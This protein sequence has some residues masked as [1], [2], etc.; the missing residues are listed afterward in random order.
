M[1]ALAAAAIFVAATVLALR[2]A[3]PWATWYYP[4]AW[5]PVLVC[6]DV[7]VARL[8]GR[9]L[10]L[11]RPRRALSLLLWSVPVWLLFEAVNF[12]VENWY[13]VFVPDRRPAAWAGIT[14]SFATILPAIFL[15]TT[16]VGEVAGRGSGPRW[17]R[18]G[19]TPVRLRGIRL[20][21]V[22]MA[23]L[24]L[25]WPR[26]FFPLVWG[27]VT[28]LVEPSNYRRHRGTSLLA[29]LEGGRP[30]RILRLVAAGAA[31]GLLWELLNGV[32]RGR[33]IYTVPGLEEL[34]LF[35][36][37]LPGFLGFPVFA[38][39]CWALYHFLVNAGV[40][41]P[42]PGAGG[43]PGGTGSDGDSRPSP[44][45]RRGRTALAG[46]AALAASVVVLLGME[47]WTIDSRTPRLRDLP[48]LLPG[49][50]ESLTAWGI[51]T[52]FRL[53]R[54]APG[55]VAARVPGVEPEEAE[56]WV[57]AARLAVLRGIGARN[58]R[59]LWSAGIRSVPELARAAAPDLARRL[60]GSGGGVEAARVRVWIRAARDEVG[61]GGTS[62]GLPGTKARV[63]ELARTGPARRGSA[64]LPG[65][66]SRAFPHPDGWH[67]APR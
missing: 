39:D 58:A 65:A 21:G 50:V 43:A 28:L 4:L 18:L 60:A 27:S 11:D 33:W 42:V 45:L 20:A 31:V 53:A 67:G 35:E 64:G 38:L 8:R 52:P 10:L 56:P 1:P 36:M 30:G 25:A 14:L 59:R 54:L 47:A 46:G 3:E 37:P 22:A 23:V 9:P 63:D 48:S 6:L 40:A 5:Y 29:D 12:R 49:S 7:A 66:P 2:G 55:E 57:R 34:K 17:P 13:Y 62:R 24:A 32:A 19:V 51:D 15:T 26:Y 44:G 41:R 61:I 16:L